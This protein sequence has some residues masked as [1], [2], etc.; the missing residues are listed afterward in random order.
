[1]KDKI[2]KE[3]TKYSIKASEIIERDYQDLM[4]DVHAPWLATRSKTQFQITYDKSVK[5]RD[6]KG[7][8]APPE[9]PERATTKGR[10]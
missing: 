10:F 3:V 8:I 2:S 4:V 6:E 5:E 1:M 7:Y 9:K